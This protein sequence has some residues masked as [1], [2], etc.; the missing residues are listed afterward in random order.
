MMRLPRWAKALLLAVVA[1]AGGSSCATNPVTGGKDF[2]LM[3]EAEERQL[4]AEYHKKILKE[5]DVFDDRALQAYVDR[6]GQRLARVS[7]R[8]KLDY[9][10]TVLDDDSVNAF[11]LPGGYI[12]IS[13]GILAYFNSEAELAGVL[14][15]EIG[16]VTARHSVRQYSTATATG[17]LGSI[18][19]IESGAGQ[20]AGDLFNVVHTA[21]MRGFGREHEL[22]S[23]RLGAEYLARAGYDSGEML[24]VIGILKDQEL[25]EIHRAK[26]EGREPRIYH[27]V[28]ST[29]PDN[30]ARLQEVVRAARKYE[31]ED[32]RPNQ[33]EAYL[34]LLDGVPFGPP[35]SQGVVDDHQF[36]HDPLDVGVSAPKGWTIANRPDRVVFEAPE[37]GAGM[38]MTLEPAGPNDNPRKRLT[39]ALG[40]I[41]DG[42]RFSAGDHEGYTGILTG[43]TSAGAG[44]MRVALVIK[45]EQAWFFRGVAPDD[46][47]FDALDDDFVAIAKSL[48]ALTAAERERAQPLHIRIVRAQPGDTYASLAGDTPRLKDAEA[49]TRLLNG[50]WPNGEPKPGQLVK[51]LRR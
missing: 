24:D 46:K 8:P 10:F 27:G 31:V 15:H 1:A 22:E 48:H 50:D 49:R 16:H 43:R 38:I 45:G 36:L 29:H 33:R 41:D 30:D 34:E 13:R 14:G 20:A 19:L 44:R 11:A 5:Q 18:L 6:I 21:A 32:P 26:E 35:A 42:E 40:E 7:H 4:G 17:I 47:T 37:K 39:D 2:V 23:D 28:F 12:Y 9:Q 3:S 25:Y 51:V